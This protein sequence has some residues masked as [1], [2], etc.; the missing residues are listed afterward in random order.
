MRIEFNIYR[1]YS[2]YIHDEL[3]IYIERIRYILDKKN[4]RDFFEYL[5]EVDLENYL[6]SY[7][8]KFNIYK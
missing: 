1:V 3:L 2:I 5:L 4:L 6:I 7:K 8:Y